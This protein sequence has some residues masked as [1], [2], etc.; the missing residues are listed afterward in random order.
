MTT[1]TMTA[2]QTQSTTASGITIR[3]RR[4]TTP[5]VPVTPVTMMTMM[6]P[7]LIL[8]TIASLTTIHCRRTP[9]P[10]GSAMSA[11][12]VAGCSPAGSPATPT[13]ARMVN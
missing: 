7:S 8:R 2:Y 10:T 11:M 9:T 12:D 13:A 4:I 1:T 5:T 3:G 6:T